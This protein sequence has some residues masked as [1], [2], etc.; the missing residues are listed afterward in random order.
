VVVQLIL[1]GHHVAPETVRIVWAAAGGRVALVTDA[2]AAAGAGDGDFRLGD[3]D[4]S[5]ENGVARSAGGA[6]AGSSLTMVEAVRNLHAAGVPVADAVAAATE[7]PARAARRDDVGSIRPGAPADVVVLDD[8][9]EIRSV[10]VAGRERLA[11]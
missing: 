10:L 8:A 4:V 7:V 11:A 9:L 2:M 3:V 5:V 1:D 6:L